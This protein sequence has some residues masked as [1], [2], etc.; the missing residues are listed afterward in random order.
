[1]ERGQVRESHPGANA[2]CRMENAEGWVPTKANLEAK[3]E[4]RMQK[5][6]RS[7]PKPTSGQEQ[8]KRRPGDWEALSCVPLVLLLCSSCAAV[9]FS[10]AP[11]RL[12]RAFALFRQDWFGCYS[13]GVAFSRESPGP[14]CPPPLPGPA[15]ECSAGFL[16]CG[17]RGRPGSKSRSII[18]RDAR[19]TRRRGGLR[20]FVNG[21]A[22][23]VRT[24]LGTTTKAGSHATRNAGFIRQAGEWH[25]GC[26]INPAFRWC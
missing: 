18:Q 3:A 21:P 25:W 26:R 12:H 5:W 6:S 16:A 9:G 8:D 14:C 15:T 1:V 20:Y 10:V 11:R 4:C 24:Q 19:S 7:H 13:N 22:G 2:E 17:V 23:L